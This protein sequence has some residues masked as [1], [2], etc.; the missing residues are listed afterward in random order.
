MNAQN[1]TESGN[2]SNS[3]VE[4]GDEV[5]TQIDQIDDLEVR[6]QVDDLEARKK[7]V[8][9]RIKEMKDQNKDDEEINKVRNAYNAEAKRKLDNLIRMQDVKMKKYEA[10]GKNL[11]NLKDFEKEVEDAK[12]QRLKREIARLERDLKRKNKEIADARAQAPR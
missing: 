2:N 1:P 12:T 9:K 10:A 3:E 7:S 8:Q 6:T 5:K 11:E 4:Q